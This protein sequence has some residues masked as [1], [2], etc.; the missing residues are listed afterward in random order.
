[1]TPVSGIVA[2]ASLTPPPQTPI[3]FTLT[4]STNEMT[5]FLTTPPPPPHLPT[6]PPTHTHTH[7]LRAKGCGAFIAGGWVRDVY[8]A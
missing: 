2:A 7:R 3:A 4:P 5:F 8:L 1:M 6:P